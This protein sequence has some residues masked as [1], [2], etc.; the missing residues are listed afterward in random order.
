MILH[1][2]PCIPI[3]CS[4]NESQYVFINIM[5]KSIYNS[6]SGVYWAIFAPNLA[7]Q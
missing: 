1:I 6:I 2:P 7:I 3:N 4:N 5:T